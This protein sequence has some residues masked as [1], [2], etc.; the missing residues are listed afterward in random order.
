MLKSRAYT[1]L[2]A[3]WHDRPATRNG[4]A[5]LAIQGSRLALQ[6]AIG[7]VLARLLTLDGMGRYAFTI[8]IMTMA[9]IPAQ[10]GMT[11]LLLR[12]TAAGRA[13]N[14]RQRIVEVWRLA[15]RTASIGSLIVTVLLVWGILNFSVLIP[16]IDSKAFFC[17]LL[18]LPM[19]VA[20]NLAEAALQGLGAPVKG[21]LPVQ[22][23]R[24]ALLL[25]AFGVS[26]LLGLRLNPFHAIGLQIACYAAGLIVALTLWH[27]EAQRHLSLMRDT[28]R[29][30]TLPQ[31][32]WLKTALS[33]V[34]IHGMW[35][36]ISN[37][38]LVML[39]IFSNA[40]QVGLYRVASSAAGMVVLGMEAL[41]PV[42]CERMSWFSAREDKANLQRVAKVGV[43]GAVGVALVLTIVLTLW[44]RRVLLLLFGATYVEAANPLTILALSQAVHVAAGYAPSLLGMSGFEKVN[45]TVLAGSAM[46]NVV[47]NYLLIPAYGASGAALA[48]AIALIGQGWVMWAVARRWMGIETSFLAWLFPTRTAPAQTTTA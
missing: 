41:N 22:I 4:V 45:L 16:A 21:A 5:N 9:V 20:A 37:T 35:V 27:L 29:R 34:L 28:P 23:V 42:I 40:E 12:E 48:S 33:F 11:T 18:L 6:M 26:L 1:G 31:T 8:A 19:M 47:L 10:F 13:L 44:G 17:G 7:I 36:V 25:L 30:K 43:A 2:A 38:D 15:L 39:G 46:L 3:K 32:S 24:S 14:D